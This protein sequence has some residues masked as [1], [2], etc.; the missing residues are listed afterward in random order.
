MFVASA[1][2]VIRNICSKG[3]K[4]RTELDQ[5]VSYA[6]SYIYPASPTHRERV[7]FIPHG[8]PHGL[9]ERYTQAHLEEIERTLACHGFDLLPLDYNL[10]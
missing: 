10:Q 7:F 6:F 3:C 2:V 9:G 4:R 5:P 1:Q 8:L